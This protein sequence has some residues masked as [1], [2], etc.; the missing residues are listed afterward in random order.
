MKHNCETLKER[1]SA[2]LEAGM[3][4]EEAKEFGAL[5]AHCP[6]ILKEVESYRMLEGLLSEEEGLPVPDGADEFFY[7][8]LEKESRPKHFA[9]SWQQ[10]A[11]AIALL[12]IGGIIGAGIS[13]GDNQDADIISLKDDIR[14]M[15]QMLVSAML[16]EHSAMDRIK[17]VSFTEEMVQP[18]IEVI[19][20]LVKS[21]TSD[22]SPNVRIAAANALE[23]WNEVPVVR[24]ELVKAMEFQRDPIVQITL[25]NIL[26]SMGEKGA[27]K[28]FRKLVEDESVEELVRKQAQIGLEVLI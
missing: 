8:Q 14:Q 5:I 17:A 9:L 10:I 2:Y 6:E 20:V 19:N 23:K 28:P 1:L 16:E 24:A 18:D 3:S 15:K 7:H 22:K 25:I 26:I 27:V 13:S 12:I 4:V 21:L 11:A